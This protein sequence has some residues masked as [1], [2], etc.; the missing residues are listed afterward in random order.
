VWA[1]AKHL[2]EAPPVL[3]AKPMSGARFAPLPPAAARAQSYPRWRKALAAHLQRAQPLRLWQCR[4][5]ELVARPGQSEAEFRA[6]VAEGARELRDAEV[7]KLRRTYATKVSKLETRLRATAA[8]LE[9]EHAQYEGERTQTA[10]SLGATVLGAM[11][12]RKLGL[13]TMGRATTAARGVGRAARQRDD[14]A[15]ARGEHAEV[16][17]ELAAL[18]KELE[19]ELDQLRREFAA[20]DFACEVLE[21]APRKSDLTVDQ[22][23][24]VWIP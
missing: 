16:E 2:G 21:I 17:A 18:E 1:A 5:L 3:A 4:A 22:L 12:G 19:A 9:R 13:G 23:S 24:L 11:F 8:R 15:R 7:E 6:R 14:V 20:R 10:I